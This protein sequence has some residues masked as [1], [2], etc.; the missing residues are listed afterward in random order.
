MSDVVLNLECRAEF[1]ESV[2]HQD[3]PSLS[4]SLCTLGMP[5]LPR[6]NSAACTSG[7]YLSLEM[8]DKTLDL[9]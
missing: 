2:F 6:R 7:M 5:P 1:A 9:V 8:T 3:R 4:L